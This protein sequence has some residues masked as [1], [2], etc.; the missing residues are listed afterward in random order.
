MEFPDEFLF[1]CL[2][3]V[4]F[5]FRGR[6]GLRFFTSFNDAGSITQALPKRV[7]GSRPDFMSASTRRR[8]IFNFAAAAMVVSILENHTQQRI[9]FKYYLKNYS[10]VSIIVTTSEGA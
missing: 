4:H 5:T 7:A 9:I 2:G 8:V 10:T 6:P 3:H 1:W